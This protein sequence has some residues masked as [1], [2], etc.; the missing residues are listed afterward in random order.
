[1]L[2]SVKKCEKSVKKRLKIIENESLF[3]KNGAKKIAC[4]VGRGADRKRYSG[5]STQVLVNSEESVELRTFSTLI[6][7]ISQI[8]EGSEKR[9]REEDNSTAD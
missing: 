3:V 8:L 2:K 9:R 6:S 7:L 5:F 4:N 1:M